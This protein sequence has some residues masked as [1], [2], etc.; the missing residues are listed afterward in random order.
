MEPGS[1]QAGYAPFVASL[2]AGGFRQ[3]DGEGW[4]AELVAAHVAL[5]NDLIAE[6]AEQ[7]AAGHDVSYDNAGTVDEAELA[8]FAAAAGS[9]AGLAREVDRSAARLERARQALG[10]RAD[11]PVHVRIT[12]GGRV[13]VDGPMPIGAFAD[14][15]AAAHLSAHLDQ[16]RALESIRGAAPPA[17]FD[18]YQ[19]VL[20]EHAPDAPH[21]GEQAAASLLAEH[22]AFF[23]KMINAGLMMT[24]GPVSNDETVGGAC[25]YRA[26]SIE[27]ARALAEDDPV[28]RAGIYAA[29]VMTWITPKGA[30]EWPAPAVWP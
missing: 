29:R 22:L 18:S 15:N 9:L 1:L 7:V 24:S 3:P 4:T 23:A 25:L 21:L 5:N 13:V 12:D 20:L 11:T 17:E 14:A 26:G 28:V 2:L 30:V 27:R 8:R 16:L 6:A 19:L 10:S